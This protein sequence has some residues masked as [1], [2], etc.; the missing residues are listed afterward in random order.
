MSYKSSTNYDWDVSQGLQKS[1]IAACSWITAICRKYWHKCLSQF[2]CTYFSGGFGY[3][4]HHISHTY[5]NDV[6]ATNELVIQS[7]R[8]QTNDSNDDDKIEIAANK[9]CLLNCNYSMSTL[10][11]KIGFLIVAGTFRIFCLCVHKHDTM[12][13]F[14]HLHQWCVCGFIQNNITVAFTHAMSQNLTLTPYDGRV[15]CCRWIWFIYGKLTLFCSCSPNKVV[16]DGLLKHLCSVLSFA[17]GSISF[18][19]FLVM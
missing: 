5:F 11:Y 15:S 8:S 1:R 6:N 19:R 14:I 4:H 16:Y 17:A 12:C 13:R 3:I 9:A 10:A 2:C 7:R 18:V